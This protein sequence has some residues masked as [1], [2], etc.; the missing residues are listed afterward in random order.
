MGSIQLCEVWNCF[1]P[2]VKHGVCG[3]HLQLAEEETD[4]TLQ[5]RSEERIKGERAV[6]AAWEGMAWSMHF[7]FQ[8][9]IANGMANR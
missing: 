4:D 7:Y 6:D 5:K 1:R 8:K 3:M 2:A 9:T